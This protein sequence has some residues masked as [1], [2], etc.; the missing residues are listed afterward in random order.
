MCYGVDR[1]CSAYSKP[2]M[3]HALSGEAYAAVSGGLTSKSVFVQL[4]IGLL[5]G[6]N[7]NGNGCCGNGDKCHGMGE[8]F[9]TWDGEKM[10][11]VVSVSLS[12]YL[13]YDTDRT[14]HNTE[15]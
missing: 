15:N 3:S 6:R 8:N 12:T 13:L 4:G 10:F 2:I 9:W 7:G 1:N 5:W 14:Q 11:S